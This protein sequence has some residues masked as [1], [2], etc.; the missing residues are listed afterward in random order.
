MKV[1][2]DGNYLLII[3][4]ESFNATSIYIA[5][6]WD[7]INANVRSKIVPLFPSPTADTTY[8]YEVT[9]AALITKTRSL[10]STI[11][12]NVFSTSLTRRALLC[13]GH[14]KAPLCLNW[15]L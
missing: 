9:M 10:L 4:I 12:L 8:E 7:G 15:L 13:F 5:P 1:T 14:Q 2:H 6:L 3:G 11:T